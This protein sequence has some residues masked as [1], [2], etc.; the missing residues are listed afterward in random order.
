MILPRPPLLD[1]CPPCHA[2][3]VDFIAMLRVIRRR[4]RC[5]RFAT[6]FAYIAL[7]RPAAAISLM[8][9]LYTRAL[10]Y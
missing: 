9:A 2:G 3:Y 4:F 7:F 1:Y 10:H 6:F 5:R 8:E